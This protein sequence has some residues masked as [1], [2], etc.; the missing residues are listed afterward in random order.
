VR[1][2]GETRTAIMTDTDVDDFA[3]GLIHL[4]GGCTIMLEST[5]ASFT[6]PACAVSVFGSKGGAI[7]DLA[8]SKENRLTIY[9]MSGET[10]VETR[11]VEVLL[12]EAPEASI[13]VHF[14]NC[15]RTGRTPDTSAERGLAEMKVLDAIY[16]SSEKR[17]E[18]EIA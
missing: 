10:Y 14:V 8:A 7:L 3:A 17:R 2:S 13:Q 4:K 15:V 5:W 12:P 6:K 18:I 1:V 9:A 11:P 16:E